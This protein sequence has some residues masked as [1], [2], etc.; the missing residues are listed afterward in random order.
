MK[1]ISEL[2]LV[3]NIIRQSELIQTFPIPNYCD[4][5]KTIMICNHFHGA[6]ASGR[7]R[8]AHAR[9]IARSGK[10][11]DKTHAIFKKRAR[12]EKARRR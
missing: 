5:S 10:L 7:S 1:I 3:Q 9:Q 4:I 6:T 11:Q 2:C 12:K 8:E